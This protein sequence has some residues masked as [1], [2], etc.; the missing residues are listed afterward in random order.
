M[1]CAHDAVLDTVPKKLSESSC[2]EDDCVGAV[3]GEDGDGDSAFIDF[4]KWRV[5]AKKEE[6]EYTKSFEVLRV[7]PEP[8]HFEVSRVLW[9]VKIDDRVKKVFSK[10]WHRHVVE[11]D[12]EYKPML[13]RRRRGFGD[14]KTNSFIKASEVHGIALIEV[15]KA[16][17]KLFYTT[18]GKVQIGSCSLTKV[19]GHTIS[20]SLDWPVFIPKHLFYNMR[21]KVDEELFN[22]APWL[23][24]S[25]V[26][27]W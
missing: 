9:K 5:E 27:D 26:S 14:S 24:L 23:N 11:K 8:S 6:E 1:G 21:I 16:R 25:D 17:D 18:L 12:E 4:D 19:S 13:L 10:F 2:E 3:G 22:H 20:R 7:L 15:P